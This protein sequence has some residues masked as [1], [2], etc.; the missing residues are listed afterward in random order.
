MKTVAIIQA[1]MGSTRLPGKVMKKVAGKSLLEQQL[2]RVGRCKMLDA[3]VVATTEKNEDDLIDQECQRL[4]IDVYRGSEDDVLS[5]YYYAAL[6]YRADVIVRLTADCPVIDPVIIDRVI[7]Y[8]HEHYP[9]YD[10]V[11]NTLLRTYPR[12]MDTEVFSFQALEKAFHQSTDASSREHVTKYIYEHPSEFHLLN[13]KHYDDLSRFRWTVDTPEDFEL[14]SKIIESLVPT[15]PDYTMKD[16]LELFELHPEWFN[17]N[18]HV[19]Q[20]KV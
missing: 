5:R 12:G 10:Y 14:I 1:R 16:I 7:G 15:K 11:S 3:V 19:E 2:M 13:V 20:K 9:D 6:E 4:G 18:A 17:I 8:Y